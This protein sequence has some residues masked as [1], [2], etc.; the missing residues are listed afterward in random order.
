VNGNQKKLVL[1]VVPAIVLADWFFGAK[2]IDAVIYS[3]LALLA[4]IAFY[5]AYYGLRSK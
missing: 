5:G 1:L 2:R 3:L 4:G